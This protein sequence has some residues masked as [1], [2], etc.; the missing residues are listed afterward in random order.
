VGIVQFFFSRWFL[1]SHLIVAIVRF[2][3]LRFLFVRP[4]K[5]ERWRSGDDGVTAAGVLCI[6]ILYSKVDKR[7]WNG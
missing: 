6:Y 2:A 3:G 4:R 1:G 5:M 7:Q